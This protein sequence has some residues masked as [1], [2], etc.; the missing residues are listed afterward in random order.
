[1][2]TKEDIRTE[3]ILYVDRITPYGEWQ[4][5]AKLCR[6]AFSAGAKWAIDQ[7]QWISTADRMPEE[8]ISV[9][10]FIPGQDYIGSAI[11]ERVEGWYETYENVVINDP[12]THWMQLPSPPKITEA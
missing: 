7:Q 4:Y 3:S 5:E 11:Y 10:V 2:I 1:M 12:V 6:E 9:I 8:L